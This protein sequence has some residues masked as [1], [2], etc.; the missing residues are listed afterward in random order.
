M[1]RMCI[2]RAI[3]FAGLLAFLNAAQATSE[4]DVGSFIDPNGA[5][6]EVG[7]RIDDNGAP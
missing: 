3:F 7:A 6:S 5:K 2:L 4:N 1:L